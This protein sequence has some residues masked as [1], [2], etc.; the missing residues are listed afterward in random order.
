MEFFENL[1]LI[2]CADADNLIGLD[3]IYTDDN[4]TKIQIMPWGNNNI[5]DLKYFKQVTSNKT[6][7]MGYGTFKSIG[8]PLPNRKN[9]VLT[10]SHELELNQE[11]PTVKVLNSF[12]EIDK[13]IRGTNEKIFIIGGASLFNRYWNQANY[14]Y[15]TE[16]SNYVLKVKEN[17]TVSKTYIQKIDDTLYNRIERLYVSEENNEIKYIRNVWEHKKY[18]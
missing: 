18:K 6:V 9:I 3:L 5:S 12:D 11:F 10:R 13:Y 16:I 7:I 4:G 14:V 17:E 8:K 1:S 2:Y 15:Q